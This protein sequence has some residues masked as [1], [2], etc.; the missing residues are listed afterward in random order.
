MLTYNLCFHITALCRPDC[1]RNHTCIAPDTCVCPTG[2]TGNGCHIGTC[3]MILSSRYVVLLSILSCIS[4]PT[5]INECEQNN[6]GCEQDCT[7]FDGGYNCTCGSQYALATDL[8]NCLGKPFP[9]H[10]F[11]CLVNA[12]CYKFPLER[13]KLPC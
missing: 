6:A 1:D 5:D 12:G 4:L 2:W 11:L 3:M 13:G 9:L 8:H 10:A 7:N